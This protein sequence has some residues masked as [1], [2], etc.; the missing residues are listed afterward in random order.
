MEEGSL[1]A[2]LPSRPKPKEVSLICTLLCGRESLRTKLPKDTE[3][4][5]ISLPGLAQGENHSPK[6]VL[7]SRTNKE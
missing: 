1:R 4:A 2:A 7:D 3:G 5:S 6:P